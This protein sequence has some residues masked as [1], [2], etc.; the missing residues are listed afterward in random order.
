MVALDEIE[1][2]E[3]H[4]KY[5][6]NRRSLL[7]AA[8]SSDAMIDDVLHVV[9]FVSNVCAFRRRWELMREFMDRM[10]RTDRVKLY[11]VELAYGSQE[12]AITDAGNP[13]HLQLRT[14]HALWHKENMINLGIRRLLPADWKAVAWID[15]DVEFENADWVDYTLKTLTAFEIVQ[16]FSVCMDLDE[17][18]VPMTLWQGFGYKFC[19]GQ[20]FTH[21]RGV[22]YW[23]CGYAWACR[24]EFYEKIGGIYDRSILGSGDYILT[25]R[26]FGS[27]ASLNKD[28]VD[29]RDDIAKHYSVVDDTAVMVGYIP[30]NIKHYFHGSKANRKYTARNEILIRIHY[31][32][33]KHI[34][35]DSQGILVPSAQMPAESIREIRDYFFE[36]NEDEYY[37]LRKILGVKQNI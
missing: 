27:I 8:L 22:N 34:E 5:G 14:E 33:V 18:D 17:N 36:R 6:V 7:N 3:Y 25:Q 11:V 9:T 32:P 20:T 1:L 26:L 4:P 29:F 15:G 12:F 23:H 24:R 31:D 30:C 37:S 19:N 35:Y 10:G 2:H 28:L 13:Q 21:Q 16:L